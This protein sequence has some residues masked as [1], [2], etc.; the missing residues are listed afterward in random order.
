VAWRLPGVHGVPSRQ[1][2]FSDSTA[3]QGFGVLTE[4]DLAA[5]LKQKLGK[6][7][8]GQVILDGCNPIRA[9]RAPGAEASIGL[10][11]P[12]NVVLRCVGPQRTL[13]AARSV[14]HGN[15]IAVDAEH[16]SSTRCPGWPPRRCTQTR[17]TTRVVHTRIPHAVLASHR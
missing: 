6:G 7:V 12:C 13:V 1:Q 10:L 9:D 2:T 16:V 11:L 17:N 4:T 3:E 5:V 14:T 15:D 8:P